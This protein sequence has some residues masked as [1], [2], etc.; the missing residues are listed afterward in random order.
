MKSLFWLCYHRDHKL[1]GVA[2]IEAGELLQARMLAAIDGIDQLADFSSGYR[3][4]DQHAAMVSAK[5]IGRMLT[6]DESGRLLAWIESEATRK[7]MR[8]PELDQML[9]ATD[10]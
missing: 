8:T 6:P 10:S 2:I 5:W 1:L 9:L 7:R 3:L 4:S